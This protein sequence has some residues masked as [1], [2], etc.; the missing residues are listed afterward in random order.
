MKQSSKQYGIAKPHIKVWCTEIWCT[1]FRQFAV[2][3]APDLRG[4]TIAGWGCDVRAAWADYERRQAFIKELR[5]GNQ[6]R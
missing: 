3:I 6:E 1:T 2:R 4:R 5:N